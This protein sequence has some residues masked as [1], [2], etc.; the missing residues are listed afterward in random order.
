MAEAGLLSMQIAE[1]VD[2]T[3]FVLISITVFCVVGLVIGR[4]F[5]N[6]KK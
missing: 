2:A 4:I 3:L 1:V 6:E 5:K